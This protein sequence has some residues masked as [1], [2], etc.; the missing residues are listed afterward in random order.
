[1]ATIYKTKVHEGEWQVWS[2]SINGEEL[3]HTFTTEEHADHYM[4]TGKIYITE[5]MV[6]GWLGSDNMSVNDFIEL[7]TE[8][9]NDEYTLHNFRMDVIEYYENNRED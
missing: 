3:L 1:M 6:E 8:L 2:S 7:L 4:N 5:E 9:I